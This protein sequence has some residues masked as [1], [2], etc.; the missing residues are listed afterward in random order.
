MRRILVWDLATRLFHWSFAGAFLAAFAVATLVGDESALFPFHMLLG[1]VLVFMVA[2][3]LIWGLIGTKHA[4]FSDLPT[5][6]GEL[7]AYMRDA[8]TRGTKRYAGH[9]PGSTWA[10]FAM[11]ALVVGLGA[12][13]LMMSRGSEA[14]EEVHE[15][16]AW[17]M[18]AVVVAHLA[19]IALHTIRHKELIAASMVDGRKQGEPADAIP[20]SRP[21]AGVAFLALT[22]A[23]AGAVFGGYDANSGQLS[24]LGATLDLG[25]QE[26]GEE[27]GE[28]EDDDD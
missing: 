9:N 18:I 10:M 2:L 5:R 26:E 24:L 20:S 16:L 11:F 14:A 3:R 27:H 15:V 19:G 6:P 13:G 25:E 28:G 7:V 23:W 21:V 22:A 1:L 8:F 4:R 17:A 12:T